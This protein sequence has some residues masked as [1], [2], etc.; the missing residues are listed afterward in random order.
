[1]FIKLGLAIQI[2]VIDITL[3]GFNKY[4]GICI[5]IQF[6]CNILSFDNHI[7]SQAHGGAGMCPGIPE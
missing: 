1:M 4:L 5:I 2:Y 6:A 3:A 7:S